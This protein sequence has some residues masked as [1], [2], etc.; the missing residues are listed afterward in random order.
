MLMI[1]CPGC[2]AQTWLTGEGKCRGCG[3]VLR[4]CVDCANFISVRS[5]CRRLGI[6]VE[7]EEAEHPGALAVSAQCREYVPIAARMVA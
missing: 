2:G 4:R 5:Q 7:Q 1:Y 6:D 3:A